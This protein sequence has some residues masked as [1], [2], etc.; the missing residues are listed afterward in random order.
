M[1]INIGVNNVA[2]NVNNIFVGV[3][4]KARKVKKAYIGVGDKAR[5]VYNSDSKSDSNVMFYGAVD[6][7]SKAYLNNNT[8]YSISLNTV[9]EYATGSNDKLGW[10]GGTI[11]P[12][13]TYFYIN[14]TYDVT[15]LEFYKIEEGNVSLFDTIAQSKFTTTEIG[16]GSNYR[17]LVIRGC[18]FSKDE[19]HLYVTSYNEDTSYSNYRKRMY[20]SSFNVTSNGFTHISTKQ[21]TWEG[22]LYFTLRGSYVVVTENED[23]LYVN[24]TYQS[25]SST[26]EEYRYLSKVQINS[27]YSIS[28]FIATGN[29]T[30][31]YISGNPGKIEV[32]PDGKWIAIYYDNGWTESSGNY[33]VA[34]LYYVNDLYDLELVTNINLTFCSGFKLCQGK[35]LSIIDRSN[36]TTFDFYVFILNDDGTYVR[37]ITTFNNSAVDNYENYFIGSS[38][39]ISKDGT[40]FIA[41]NG[42]LKR[43]VYRLNYS[44]IANSVL[45]ITKIETVDFPDRGYQY[46]AIINE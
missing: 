12:K 17:T 5:L 7:K 44:N 10:S 33:R 32:T 28:P 42:Y 24:L 23:W 11:S 2:K 37:K 16:T 13:G 27:D 18:C 31:Y 39:A 40:I 22:N 19:N 25:G 36:S 9:T 41:G 38:S 34:Y 20:V 3:D 46:C 15:S 1:G 45:T 30:N 35:L 26:T 21:L 6:G 43:I 8:N 4:G 29:I 14:P